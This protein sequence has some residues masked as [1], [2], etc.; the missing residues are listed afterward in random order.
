MYND[1]SEELLNCN[2]ASHALLLCY[3]TYQTTL[4]EASFLP[5]SLSRE[6]W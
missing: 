5:A 3:V 4:K 2:F 1:D 6:E